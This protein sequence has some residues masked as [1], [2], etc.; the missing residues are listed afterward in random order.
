LEQFEKRS[1]DN[2][3]DFSREE[4]YGE[5]APVQIPT[6]RVRR[7]LNAMDMYPR[8]RAER[9]TQEDE[10]YDEEPA[11]REPRPRYY[12][13]KHTGTWVFIIVI[14]LLSLGAFL[15]TYVFNRATIT[16]TPKYSDI[17]DFRKSIFFTTSGDSSGVPY[18]IAT[19]TIT[20]SRTLSLSETRKVEAKASGKITIY[21]DYDGEPQ[22]LIK[23]TR[24]ESTAG[25]I[26][27]INQSITVPGK[28][29]SGPGTVEA[30]IYADSYGSDY[31]TDSSNFVIVGFKGTPR[32]SGFYA[33]SKGP[34]AGGSSGNTSLA[35]LSDINAAK[36]ELALEL[37]QDVKTELMKIKKE[38]YTGLYGASEVTY[39]DNTADLLRGKTGTY[40]VTATGYV[41]LADS[42]KLAQSI[43][44]SVRDYA[45]EDVRLGYN[46]TLS[47]TRKTTDHIASSTSVS[48]L[49]EGKPRIIWE[50]DESAIKTTFLGKDRDEFKPLM[51]TISSIESAEISFS[52]MW[53][54]SFPND[55][56]KIKVV[57]SLPK[58]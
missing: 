28:T 35:S 10:R 26:Y 42:K 6:K 49:V 50:N 27:R 12:K 19:T 40:E 18:T 36:D 41:L 58:R 5:D 57:E 43:A 11:Y 4:E 39:S 44:H 14:L 38:G 3:Q 55:R 32:E 20:K 25:K 2:E 46:E 7:D 16:I 13:Q 34:I 31:N 8:R 53:L 33:K 47:F 29:S 52:P 24:F 1:Y 48:I 21:N 51:K 45:N 30:T 15:F 9:P 17:N 22:K 37:A 56:T 23:N 54:S